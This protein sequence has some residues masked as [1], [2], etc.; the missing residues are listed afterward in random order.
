M[1]GCYVL[2]HNPKLAAC[3]EPL[4]QFCL[5]FSG[6]CHDV[7]HTGKLNLFEINSESKLALRYNDRAV[8]ENHHTSQTFRILS[9]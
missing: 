9:H 2:A 7:D 4:Q 8:L 6:L 3:L 5:V 1:S